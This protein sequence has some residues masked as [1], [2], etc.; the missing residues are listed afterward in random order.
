[1]ANDGKN[2][3]T[4]GAPVWNHDPGRLRTGLS[5]Y[6]REVRLIAP[7]VLRVPGKSGAY[8][9]SV[10]AAPSPCLSDA[11]VDHLGESIVEETLRRGGSLRNGRSVLA[12]MDKFGLG[13]DGRES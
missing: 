1:M 5:L 3:F 10:A 12:E 13:D 11:D 4:V 2:T 7:G 6:G 8:A 9:F